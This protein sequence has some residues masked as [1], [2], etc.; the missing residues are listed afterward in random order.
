M[1]PPR[2][3]AWGERH[4]AVLLLLAAGLVMRIMAHAAFGA[5]HLAGQLSPANPAYLEMLQRHFGEFLLFTHTKPP[6]IYLRDLLLVHTVG[7]DLF[8]MALFLS[9]A[10]LG[11][12]SAWPVLG[13]LRRLGVSPTPAWN[14][15]LF[16]SALM[17][18]WEYWRVGTFYDHPTPFFLLLFLYGWGELFFRSDRPAVIFA[19]IAGGLLILCHAA[20]ML[21]VPLAY[22]YL[23]LVRHHRDLFRQTLRLTWLPL[24]LLLVLMGKNLLNVGVAA[25]S[26]VGGQNQLQF[27]VMDGVM[28]PNLDVVEQLAA[29]QHYPPWYR[30]CFRQG[31]LLTTPDAAPDTRS[32]Y[33]LCFPRAPGQPPQID[34]FRQNFPHESQVL[35]LL[36]QDERDHR[37]RPW[38]FLGAVEESTTRFAAH[39]GSISKG[40]WQDAMMKDPDR[41][42][43]KALYVARLFL[44]EGSAF[45]E[46]KNFE[47]G[48][49][50]PSRM[51]DLLGEL[52][53]WIL[54]VGILAA[55]ASPLLLLIGIVPALRPPP[56][57][58]PPWLLAGGLALLFLV[59][60]A[61]FSTLTC[62]ENQRIFVNF[63]PF[64][65]LLGIV[66]LHAPRAWPTRSRTMRMES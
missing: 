23:L 38:I 50:A 56:H 8:P 66:V 44:Q 32:V 22:G 1:V 58:R 25:T 19:A 27:A 31:R 12:L 51:L 6:G 37:Q 57:Q 7:R 30:W 24:A 26:T 43:S 61:A 28:R 14:A 54:R 59:M 47:P 64:P 18:I 49:M 60:T 29:E 15:T 36:E 41:F 40:L 20:A 2:L 11:T 5:E 45:F 42:L 63:S 10:T 52:A 9:T 13:L 33:G 21:L 55:L 46:G 62:C 53:T 48:K 3:A 65:F 35:D 4:A 16:W 17:M 34:L 39:Y